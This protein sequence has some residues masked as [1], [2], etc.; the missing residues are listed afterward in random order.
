MSA[1]FISSGITDELSLLD[2]TQHSHL[3]LD[4]L[5]KSLLMAILFPN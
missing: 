3:E 5:V 1:D 2:L 4:L